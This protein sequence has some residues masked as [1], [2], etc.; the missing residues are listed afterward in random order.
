MGIRERLFG[1]KDVAGRRVVALI[2]CHLNQNAR[3]PGAARYPAVNDALLDLLRGHEVGLLQIPCPE[4]F[5]LGLPRERP[6]GTSIRENLEPGKARYLAA[7]V[8]DRIEEYVRHGRKVVAILGGDIQSPGCAVHVTGSGLDP[9]RSG[10]FMLALHE[11]LESRGIDVPFR[12]IR[13]SDPDT[14]AADLAWIDT[15]LR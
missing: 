4:M 8:A 3:D 14:F 12:G 6:A 5:C 2:E 9:E 13:E 1:R 15:T 10:I 11:V 7:Q